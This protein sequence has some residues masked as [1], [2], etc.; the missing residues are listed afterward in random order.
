M[1]LSE[2]WESMKN[3]QKM[4]PLKVTEF[5]FFVS[6]FTSS[7]TRSVQFALEVCAVLGALAYL[8]TLI[9]DFWFIWLIGK[10]LFLSLFPQQ[11]KKKTYSKSPEII[12]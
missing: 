5:L 4:N 1:G 3:F 12:T 7:L 10:I 11:K 9:S 6:F 8:G 2:Y